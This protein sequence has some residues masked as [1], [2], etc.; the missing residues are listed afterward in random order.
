MDRTWYLL[1][2]ISCSLRTVN[3][4]EYHK[5][6]NF[7]ETHGFATSQLYRSC[8]DDTH[9]DE[10]CLYSPVFIV[11]YGQNKSPDIFP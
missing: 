3:T 6:S 9:V 2:E 1:V 8:V 7:V 11:G 5:L 10:H 4:C